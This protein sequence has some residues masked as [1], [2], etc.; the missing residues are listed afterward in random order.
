MVFCKK[1]KKKHKLQIWI[2]KLGCSPLIKKTTVVVKKMFFTVTVLQ[3]LLLVLLFIDGIVYHLSCSR[4]LFASNCYAVN[5][6][7]LTGF[8][9]ISNIVILK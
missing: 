9:F 8:C 4:N 7:V 5:A 1:K 6:P 2:S 3:V